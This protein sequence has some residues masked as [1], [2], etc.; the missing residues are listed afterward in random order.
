MSLLTALL[1][2]FIGPIVIIGII[3]LL[4]MAPSLAKGPRYRPGT[5]G[6]EANASEWFGAIPGGDEPAGLEA[7]G[8]PQRQLATAAAEDRLSDQDTGGASA[9]W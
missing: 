4:V 8:T 1:V 3:V 5:D 2:F 7:A 9:R 6:E